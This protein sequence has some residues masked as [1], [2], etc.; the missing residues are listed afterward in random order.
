[1]Y[2]AELDHRIPLLPASLAATEQQHGPSIHAHQPIFDH[3]SLLPFQLP[4]DAVEN[5]RAHHNLPNPL[6]HRHLL[7]ARPLEERSFHAP[8][9]P[10]DPQGT[11]GPGNQPVLKGPRE[12]L[13]AAPYLRWPLF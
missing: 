12:I 5:G 7:H 4:P 3:W 10:E 1:M 11:E 6:Q 8:A 2:V 13:P 9:L